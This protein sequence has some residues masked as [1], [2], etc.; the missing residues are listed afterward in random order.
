[1]QR[2]LGELER[3]QSALNK[4]GSPEVCEEVASLQQKTALLAVLAALTLQLH[5]NCKR[6]SIA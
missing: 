4:G 2:V 6:P 1:V 3:E 5:C